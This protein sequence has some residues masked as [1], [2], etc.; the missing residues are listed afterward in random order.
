VFVKT[1]IDL[2]QGKGTAPA[3][4]Q[5]ARTERLEDQAEQTVKA[6][7]KDLLAEGIDK[8]AIVTHRD[9]IIEWLETVILPSEED[10]EEGRLDRPPATAV[11]PS[12]NQESLSDPA[13]GRLY[14][15]LPRILPSEDNEE[16]IVESPPAT[17]VAPST[18]QE[19]LSDPA[20]GRL[21]SNLS[22]TEL[23]QC[24]QSRSVKPKTGTAEFTDPRRKSWQT[25]QPIN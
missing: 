7:E 12:I 20:Q 10:D 15:N 14:S 3:Y 1:Y 22:G 21:Y 19:S 24:R 16:R 17:V 6:A 18:N 5:V 23:T 2:H 13:E 25:S 8:N 11:A 9:L 4:S